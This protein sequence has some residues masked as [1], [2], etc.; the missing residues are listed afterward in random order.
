[1]GQGVTR[2]GGSRLGVV[3]SVLVSQVK[4]GILMDWERQTRDALENLRAALEALKRDVLPLNERRYQIMAEPVVDMIGGLE[5]ELRERQEKTARDCVDLVGDLLPRWVELAAMP[6]GL[7]SADH[8][9]LSQDL[10]RSHR[11]FCALY[12]LQRLMIGAGFEFKTEPITAQ[13]SRA[14]FVEQPPGQ[15]SG[16][17]DHELLEVAIYE[18]ARQALGPVEGVE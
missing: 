1:M 16:W 3:G 18:A 5:K 10:D 2:Q 6:P 13:I 11:L 17:C 12:G 7:H 9:Q 8:L 14:Q 15:R 4:S